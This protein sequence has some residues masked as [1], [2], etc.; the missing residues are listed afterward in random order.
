MVAGKIL[1]TK[2]LRGSP[3]G[4]CISLS[5]VKEIVRRM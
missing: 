3:R 2:E 4:K 1:G 5:E